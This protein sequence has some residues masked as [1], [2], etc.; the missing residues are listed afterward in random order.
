MAQNVTMENK[1]T[2]KETEVVNSCISYLNIAG[3][4]VWRNNSGFFKH[5]YTT[6]AGINKRSVMRAGV[7]GSSDILGVTKDGKFLAVECKREG[8]EVTPTQQVFL[9]EITA[10]GGIAIVAYS[11]YDLQIAGL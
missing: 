4:Y 2:P 10:H 9:D 8:G 1:Y 5:D 11:I 3:H 6:K 7:K